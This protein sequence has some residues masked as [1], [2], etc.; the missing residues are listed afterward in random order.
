MG[1]KFFF[2][3]KFSTVWEQKDN[4]ASKRSAE[5]TNSVNIC[6]FLFVFPV[7]QTSVDLAFIL[8][9][10]GSVGSYNFNQVKNFVKNVVD[11]FNIGSSGTHVAVV[12]YSTYSRLEFNLKAY[13]T[14]SSIKNA[15]SYIGYRGGWTYTADAL[16]FTRQNIFSKSQVSR[17]T[18]W[19]SKHSDLPSLPPSLDPGVIIKNIEVLT[20]DMRLLLLEIFW[21]FLGWVF[22]VLFFL[23]NFFFF[24][25]N[26]S[27][28][29]ALNYCA[30]NVFRRLFSRRVS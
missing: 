21:C 7:C 30:Q 10:S 22:I 6:P 11:F 27:T 12:T 8:D 23:Q 26:V 15:V 13:Y 2:H 1:N 4:P 29:I 14:K 5:C 19:S 20:Y 17:P 16:D 25:Q 28:F 18:E 24:S 3:A 9:G